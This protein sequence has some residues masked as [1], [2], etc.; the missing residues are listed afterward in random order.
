ML[1]PI[2]DEIIEKI[3]SLVMDA[4]EADVANLASVIK[5]HD[6]LM[7]IAEM[8]VDTPYVALM[9]VAQK[10]AEVGMKIVLQESEDPEQSLNVMI[11]TTSTLQCM[12]REIANGRNPSFIPIP[13]GLSLSASAVFSVMDIGTAEDSKP[14]SRETAVK[15]TPEVAV[16]KPP[17]VAK[18]AKPEP[19]EELVSATRPA[20]AKATIEHR[21]PKF[22]MGSLTPSHLA[23][24]LSEFDDLTEKAE[25]QLLL[26]EK[27][28]VQEPEAIQE[29]LGVFHTIKGVSGIIKLQALIDLAHTSEVLLEEV[30][31]VPKAASDLLF[32]AVDVFKVYSQ[33]LHSYHDQQKFLDVPDVQELLA[34]LKKVEMP[35][36]K[37]VSKPEVKPQA[38]SKPK[39]APKT[40]PLEEEFWPEP[41]P[42]EMPIEAADIIEE[43]HLKVQRTQEDVKIKI[44]RLDAMIDA[45][46]ELVIAQAML[47][48]DPEIARVTRAQTTRNI[49]TMS[50]I[51]RQLQSLAMAMRMTTIQST[52]QAMQRVIRD[53]AQKQ[54]KLAEVLVYGE[55]TELDR[56]L[57]EA[58]YNPLVHLV[59]NAIDHGLETPEKRKA[60]GKP[61]Q[62]IILLK[63]YQHGGNVVIEIKD[64]GQ[65]LNRDKI[66]QI[67]IDKGLLHAEQ[68]YSDEEIYKVIFLPGFSTASEVT[69]VSGRGV[70][71]DVV[72]KAIEKFRGTVEVFTE[73]GKGA[74]FRLN[75]P[76]TLAIIDGMLV[77]VGTERYIIPLIHI[78]E[79]VQVLPEQ[80][81]TITG[82]GEVLMLRGEIVPVF[83]LDRLLKIHG[84]EVA[85]RGTVGVIISWEG[86]RCCMLVHE[87]TN[88]QQVVIKSLGSD[89]SKIMGISGAAI[90]GDGRVGLI[91]DV[92]NILTLAMGGTSVLA[93]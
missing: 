22:D 78:E 74:T 88:Q 23:D 32:Q 86:K 19:E 37:A 64:D 62:G 11:E 25:Q 93:G 53:V 39:I 13:D 92:Q 3:D 21:Y 45:V 87:L 46:G 77:K 18:P 20:A 85:E 35:E 26:L 7:E 68:Q 54:G 17:V 8:A 75:L 30:P 4:V 40:V 58:M 9:L 12:A 56:N 51:S 6:Q 24:F 50:K 47:E 61:E 27:A 83:H 70:G 15:A 48:N 5:V 84:A 29:L 52:F 43:K 10:A 55:S 44:S 79:F 28:E 2:K 59:R 14:V 33:S 72:K 42:E 80:I 36:P 90:L 34:Q 38:V 16:A 89:F 82:K 31:A 81:S 1:D 91:L 69:E 76:L 63:A 57:I 73:R 41:E 49:T 60:A 71:L 66:L 65:G 67:A